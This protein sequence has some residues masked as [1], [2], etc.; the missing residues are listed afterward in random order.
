VAIP[1]SG[2]MGGSSTGGSPRS[3]SSGPR[4]IASPFSQRATYVDNDDDDEPAIDP[5]DLWAPMG[6]PIPPATSKPP[7]ASTTCSMHALCHKQQVHECHL[8]YSA[9]PHK[10][11]AACIQTA[12]AQVSPVQQNR[13]MSVPLYICSG[14]VGQE[15]GGA[16][17]C[18]AAG[19]LGGRQ[20]GDAGDGAAQ[21]A[22]PA[23]K[24]AP[25]ALPALLAA[26]AARR[27]PRLRCVPRLEA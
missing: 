9:Q 5:E 17:V 18:A 11:M 19:A 13:L 2:S 1:M 23:L 4:A 14:L 24:A 15:D 16:G 21:R 7:G 26:A 12:A 25:A 10:H 3:G 8:T 6:T 27:G 22:R 20:P